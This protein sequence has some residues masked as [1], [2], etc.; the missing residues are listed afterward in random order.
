MS[1]FDEL[2]MQ[3]CANG[4]DTYKDPISGYQVL[5]SEAL[6]KKVSVAVTHV[7]TVLLGI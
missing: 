7:G 3:A 1:N 6:L 5:T 4:F 2:N